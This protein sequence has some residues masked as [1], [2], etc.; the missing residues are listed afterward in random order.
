MLFDSALELDV[1]RVVAAKS[2]AAIDQADG[3]GLE[4]LARSRGVQELPSGPWVVRVSTS[5]EVYTVPNGW[6]VTGSTPQG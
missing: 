2:K 5:A 6:I 1:K 4:G 3:T